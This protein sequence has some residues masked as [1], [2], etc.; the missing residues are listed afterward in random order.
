MADPAILRQ[1]LAHRQRHYMHP[2]LL[3]SQ[4]AALEWPADA[5][6]VDAAR[7]LDVVCADV[8]SYIR[9]EQGR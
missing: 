8:A 7:S 5:C 1:R 9:K 3:G 4:L 6:V 2:E